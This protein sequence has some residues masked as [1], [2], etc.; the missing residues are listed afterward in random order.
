M[1]L[2]TTSLTD[3]AA[4]PRASPSS[5]VRMTPSRERASWKAVGRRH[6]VL[7]GH[8]VDDQERVVGIHGPGDVP[9]LVHEVLVD[10]Q[11]AGGVDDQDVPSQPPGLLETGGGHRHRIGGLAEHGDPG[12]AAEDPE[13]LDGGRALEVGPDQERVPALLLEPAGQLGR[14]GGLAR[15]LEAGQQDDR[16]RPTGVGDPERLAAEDGDQLLVDDLDDLLAR[17]QVLGQLEAHAPRPD[18]L[19]EPA[20]DADLDVGLEQGGSDLAEDLV[21][22]GVAQPAPAAEAGE[23]PL[24]SVGQALEHGALR[25]QDADRCGGAPPP[26]VD[27]RTGRTAVRTGRR[28]RRPDR[29]RP[30][31]RRPRPGPTSFTGSPSSRWMATTMPPLAVPSSLVSTTPDTSTASRN[32]LAWVSP[33]WPVVAS[34]TSSTSTTRPGGRSAT[35]RIFFSSSMRLTLLCRRP[36]VSASTTSWPRDAARCDGVEHHR[37][38]VAAL[39]PPHDV[40]VGPGGPQRQLL[41][42]RG[43]EG[44]AGGQQDLGPRPGIRLATLP[45]VVVL[46]TPLT[47]TNSQTSTGADRRRRR[48][49]AVGPVGRRPEP[50]RARQRAS[51]DVSMATRSALS[52]STS[53]S[54]PAISPALTRVRSRRAGR[55][56]RRRRRRPGSAPPR[57]RPRSRRRSSPGADRS[58]VAG[59]QAPGLAQPAPVGGRLGP[60]RPVRARASGWTGGGLDRRGAGPRWSAARLGGRRSGPARRRWGR[61]WPP[62]RPAHGSSAPRP[63]SRV[64]TATPPATST[65]GTAMTRPMTTSESPSAAMHRSQYDVAAGVGDRPRRRHAVDTGARTLTR[66]RCSTVGSGSCRRHRRSPSRSAAPR[67]PSEGPAGGRQPGSPSIGQVG[68]R[69]LTRR[70][71]GAPGLGGRSRARRRRRRRRLGAGAGRPGQPRRCGRRR[72]RAWPVAP[73]SERVRPAVRSRGT[74]WLTTLDDPPGA[75]VTP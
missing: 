57:D 30:G 1:G 15:A 75:I 51:A 59:Q 49:P 8:G 20:D 46:P 56:W 13:L 17:A 32:T 60:V 58:Q 64:P 26:A 68:G 21:D 34:S 41:P 35:R 62:R 72:C 38:R 73:C 42:G 22:V 71:S 9:D 2:P 12:L 66:G 52:A 53:A 63:R 54:G 33:F 6:G 47:P 4:P 3:R 24:E 7:A 16:R 40:G 61:R 5:L 69:R 44:V 31:P 36:A 18:R 70:S 27:G 19:G 28:R 11:A 23:D 74:F 48:R 55:R 39:G 43:P 25:L 45:T 37:A 65:T 50:C 14:G 29:S 10:G 67:G